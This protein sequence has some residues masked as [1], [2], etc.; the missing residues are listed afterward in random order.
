M[1]PND[2]IAGGLFG[3]LIGDALGVPYS[4][5]PPADLPPLEQID[6]HPPAGFPR[7]H[8]QIP[9]GTWSDDGA[10]A[11]ALLDSLLACDRLDLNDFALKIRAWY[12]QSAYTVDGVVFDIGMQTLKAIQA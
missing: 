7:S 11:L 1:A 2:R 3:L 9:P 4:F 6:M 12:E 10:L 5:H 8:P